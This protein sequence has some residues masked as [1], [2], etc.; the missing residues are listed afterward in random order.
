VQA[1]GTGFLSLF[2]YLFSFLK[3]LRNYVVPIERDRK[4]NVRFSAAKGY[5]VLIFVFLSCV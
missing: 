3:K 5:G 2:F 4:Q 1:R